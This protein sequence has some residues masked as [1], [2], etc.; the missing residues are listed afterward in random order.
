[1]GKPSDIVQVKPEVLAERAPQIYA[2]RMERAKRLVARLKDLGASYVF[3]DE[4]KEL[5]RV[6]MPADAV[7]A[8][9]RVGNA[10]ILSSQVN[11]HMKEIGAIVLL[12]EG[13]EKVMMKTDDKTRKQPQ[14][15]ITKNVFET[16]ENFE[17]MLSEHPEGVRVMQVWRE[18][19]MGI[20]YSLFCDR[21]RTL[22]SKGLLTMTH[23][24]TSQ[25]NRYK[26]PLDFHDRKAN[27]IVIPTSK[28][29]GTP[30]PMRAAPAPKLEAPDL[31]EGLPF[32]PTSE[33]RSHLGKVI[34][35]LESLKDNIGPTLALLLD[36]DR[37]FD[38]YNKVREGLADLKKQ[39]AAV[40]I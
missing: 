36:L 4:T 17:L 27:V 29:G 39:L 8:L 19:P 31:L 23:A 26:L 38:R 37:D 10:E 5:M 32:T 14:N 1:M 12:E 16:L 13:I 40:R 7:I 28:R 22:V 30:E 25:S 24:P 33:L 21:V 20:G 3:D 6:D 35:G 18:F 34:E 15:L 11:A 2:T 9:Q